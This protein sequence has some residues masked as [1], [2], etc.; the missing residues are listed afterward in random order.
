[1]GSDGCGKSDKLLDTLKGKHQY[2]LLGWIWSVRES[3]E[4]RVIPRFLL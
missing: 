1:M 4:T 3:D 2:L